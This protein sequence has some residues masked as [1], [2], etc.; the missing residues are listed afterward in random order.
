[1][2]KCEKCGNLQPGDRIDVCRKNYCGYI[3]HPVKSV[4]ASK[5]PV[6]IPDEIEK[7]PT[8]GEDE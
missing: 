3:C 5:P 7:K 8:F 4:R 6:K 1:M 2:V